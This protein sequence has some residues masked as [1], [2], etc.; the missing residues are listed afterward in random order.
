MFADEPRFTSV[1]VRM[2]EVELLPN[3]DG[4]APLGRFIHERVKQRSEVER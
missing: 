2:E 4:F 3:G 1:R